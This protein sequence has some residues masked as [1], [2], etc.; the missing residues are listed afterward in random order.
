MA[1]DN[2]NAIAKVSTIVKNIVYLSYEMFQQTA[3]DITWH[4]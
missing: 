1:R 2:A 3:R 4:N